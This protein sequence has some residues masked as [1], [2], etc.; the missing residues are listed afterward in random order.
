MEQEQDYFAK[1]L[2]KATGI[3]GPGTSPGPVPLDDT[4]EP[5]RKFRS[6]G[7]IINA[8]GLNPMENADKGV[9]EAVT[10][11]GSKPAREA[12]T[13]AYRRAM[14]SMGPEMG[15][16]GDTFASKYPRIAAH[17]KP[18]DTAMLSSAQN[19]AEVAPGE[20]FY[21]AQRLGRDKVYD[22]R[23]EIRYGAGLKPKDI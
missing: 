16:A 20:Q 9:T 18:T 3:G 11:F 19:A 10:L 13:E 8:L 1:I 21:R 6:I 23:I 12:M 5:L 14:H 4:E 2:G 22:P 7:D 17:M 15:V